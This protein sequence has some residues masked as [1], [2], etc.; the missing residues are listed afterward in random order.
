MADQKKY[1]NKLASAHVLIIG[2]SSGLGYSVAEASLEEGARVTISSSQQSRVDSSI[3]RLLTSYPSARG[4][5]AGYACD[6]TGSDVEKSIVSLFEKT[7]KIDHLVFTAGD[8]LATV[9]IKDVTVESIH[10]AGAVR[11]VAPLLVAKHAPKYLNKGPVSSITFTTGTVSEKPI[12]DWSVVA[13]YASAM[14]GMVK[15]LA[16]DLKPIR[17]NLI[18][19]GVVDTEM[20]AFLP[21][22][23]RKSMM[24]FHREK[25]PTGEVATPANVA[26]SYLYAMKDYN[27]TGISIKTDSGATLV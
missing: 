25:H 26:E 22:E 11:F 21:E 24:D 20:W 3:Q 6:L 17:V 13:G 1:T 19:P 16:L 5:V 8:K 12:P 10:K 7:G 18:S 2:G 27:A 9:P 15:N 14:H 23:Q 4:R